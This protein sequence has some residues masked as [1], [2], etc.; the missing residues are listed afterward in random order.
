VDAAK[1]LYA[2][3]NVNVFYYIEVN[4][5]VD[6]RDKGLRRLINTV[7]PY[8]NID[9]ISYSSYDFQKFPQLDY[10][11][12]LDYVE[13]KLPA[14]PSIT[15]KRVF[16]GEMGYNYLNSNLSGSVHDSNNRDIFVKALNWGC[17]FVLYW[18]FYNNE[19]DANGISQGF[20][21]IT[22]QNVKTPL[23]YTFSNLYQNGKQYVTDYKKSHGILPTIQEYQAWAVKQLSITPV[24]LITTERNDT[25]MGTVTTTKVYDTGVSA[26]VTAT[27]KTGYKFLKWNDGTNDVSTNASYTFT[28]SS[29]ITLT[30][31]FGKITTVLN[32]TDNV[33]KLKYNPINSAILFLEGEDIKQVILFNAMGQQL[34]NDNYQ[35]GI[36]ISFYP[37]GVYVGKVLSGNNQIS[38]IRFIKK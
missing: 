18:E 3:T 5:C 32:P 14:K 13:S 19:I 10:N 7:I 17:P 31:N 9:Y 11:A 35:K 21:L 15:G 6:A 27:P 33:V 12:L 38:I 29:D 36:N 22:D 25:L 28:T 37:N 23:Y 2:H 16:I 4:R 30:A 1:A 24:C 34:F 20:W 8:T 26:T